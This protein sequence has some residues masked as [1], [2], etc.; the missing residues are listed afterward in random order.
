MSEQRIILVGGGAFAR[1]LLSWILDAADAAPMATV[2]AFL[3]RDA[4]AMNAFPELQLTWVGNPEDYDP[5]PGDRFAIALGDPATKAVICQTL[6]SKGADFLSVVHPSATVSRSAKLGK[7]VVIGPGSYIATHAVLG[8]FAC[9]NSLTGVGH[10]AVVGEATTI[11]SQ[12]DIMGAV[13]LADEVF[14]G[15]GARLLPRISVGA[16]AKIGAGAIVVRSVKPGTTMFAKPA[17]K[18]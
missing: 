11:S 7:G 3:D 6:A 15:S 2:T 16:R 17:G 10:D 12:V 18:L 5:Q 4:D 13:V 1:E 8:D 14:V 9:V